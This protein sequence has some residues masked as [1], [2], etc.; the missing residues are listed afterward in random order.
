M[1]DF[2]RR[3]RLLQANRDGPE[4]RAFYRTLLRYVGDRA[5]GVW[6][7]R[8]ADVITRPELED[9]VAE[10]GLQ[11]VTGA[12]GRFQGESLPELFAY[13]RT[14]TDR[15]VGHFARRR[16]R[17][18]DLLR[19][20][21]ADTIRNWQV[22][23][24]GPDHRPERDVPC[25]LSDK[26]RDYLLDLLEAGSKAEFA[27]QK[28]RSRAAVTRMVQRIRARIDDMAEGDRDAAE[29][30]MRASA[31]RAVERKVEQTASS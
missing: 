24:P 5:A 2:Q 13:V 16:I 14:I 4:A 23:V 9:L 30:W 6:Q 20:T 3:L 17:E 25:P 12:L 8:Y 31:R 10:V 1:G 11:L 18:R 22:A 15:T 26:D 27:R 21:E 28:D 19:S 7:R 29:A